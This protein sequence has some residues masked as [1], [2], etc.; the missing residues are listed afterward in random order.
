MKRVIPIFFV[1]L[2]IIIVTTSCS[3]QES[4]NWELWGYQDAAMTY[5]NTHSEFKD[6]YGDNYEAVYIGGS[7]ERSHTLFWGLYKGT[8]RS[9]IEIN[10]DEWVI[11]TS[12]DY[13]GEWKVTGYHLQSEES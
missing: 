2:S 5:I 7:S 9:T 1:L 10:G 11:E 13:C 4:E 12:K 3:K 6:L 8:G